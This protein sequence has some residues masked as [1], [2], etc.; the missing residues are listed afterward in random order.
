MSK[1][2]NPT[3]D[4]LKEELKSLKIEL[5]E[6]IASRNEWFSIAYESYD[7][8]T[9]SHDSDCPIYKDMNEDCTCGVSNLLERSH[10]EYARMVKWDR[11]VLGNPIVERPIPNE[12]KHKI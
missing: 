3:Q 8:L 10:Q 9:N 12:L 4:S 2:I 6:A 5:K 11:T 1:I 7:Y